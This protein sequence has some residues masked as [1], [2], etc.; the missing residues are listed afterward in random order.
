MAQ[1]IV[2]W[3]DQHLER[4]EHVPGETWHLSVRAPHGRVTTYEIDAC[5]ECAKP[6]TELV[7]FLSELGRTSDARGKPLATLDPAVLADSRG[8]AG[9]LPCPSCGRMSPNRNALRSHVRTNH[10]TTLDALEGNPTPHT[11][12]ACD[13]ASSRRQGLVLHVRKS[14]PEIETPP[15]PAAAS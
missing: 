4:N 3:C 7:V 1:A 9:A 6:F 14:H 11:C 12:P 15:P 10:G 2:V 5:E 13:F 8:S